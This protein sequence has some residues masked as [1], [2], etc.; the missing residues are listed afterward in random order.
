MGDLKERERKVSGSEDWKCWFVSTVKKSSVG[1]G[2]DVQSDLS[3]RLT[4][5]LRVPGLSPSG[6]RDDPWTSREWE[7]STS[8]TWGR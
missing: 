5:E 6:T 4:E 7:P 3:D 2:Q 8:P 1:D